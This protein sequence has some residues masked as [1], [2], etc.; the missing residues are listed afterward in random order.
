MKFAEHGHYSIEQ[1]ND[2]IVV[3]ATGPF[4]EQ[5]V[6]K[7]KKELQ[8]IILGLN[9][10]KWQQ[11]IIMNDMSIFTPEAENELCKTIELRKKHGLVS[12]AVVYGDKLCNVL[13]NEQLSRC[14]LDSKM[15]H[16]FFD[17]LEKAKQWVTS[18]T[19]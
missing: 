11:I 7:Y 15:P 4:N 2:F 13:I 19:H 10:R 14:Y 1:Y 8:S 12:L 6:L 3:D 5:L 18:N 17:N 16:K 9:G